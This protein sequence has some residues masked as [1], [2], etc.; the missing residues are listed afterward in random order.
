[1]GDVERDMRVLVT[2][3]GGGVLIAGGDAVEVEMRRTAERRG[4]EDD[5]AGGGGGGGGRAAGGGGGGEGEGEAVHCAVADKVE[6][7]ELGRGQR[8]AAVIGER[9]G[10]E[11]GA[12]GH[13]GDGAG[14]DHVGID[15]R[16]RG[17]DV[18][19]DMRVLVTGRGGGVLIA[20][21]DAVEVEMR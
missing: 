21:G 13:A 3:R 18:E 14:Y 5:G 20:G 12:R 11:R 4:G 17:G 10:G 8:V 6:P 1:G 16:Q 2:G 9:A 7:A 15:F 19:R